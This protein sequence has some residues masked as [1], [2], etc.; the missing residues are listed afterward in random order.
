MNVMDFQSRRAEYLTSDGNM[1]VAFDSRSS[2]IAATR[3]FAF[4]IFT[5]KVAR[6]ARSYTPRDV[7]GAPVFWAGTLT[8]QLRRHATGLWRA[9]DP[10]VSHEG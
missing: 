9:T 7:L 2:A 4:S 6:T 8:H 5:P 3:Q 1:T 10:V